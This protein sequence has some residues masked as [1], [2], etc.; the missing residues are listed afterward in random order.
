MSKRGYPALVTQCALLHIA[1]GE[2]VWNVCYTC[3][4]RFSRRR[5]RLK[6]GLGLGGTFAFL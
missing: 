5:V 6:G 2:R 3:F 4:L 1:R